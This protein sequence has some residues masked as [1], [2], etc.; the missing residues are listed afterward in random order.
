VQRLD[1]YDLLIRGDTSNDSR[2]L[3]GDVIFIP[4]VGPTASVTGE[5][6]RPAIYELRGETSIAD[7]VQIAGGLTPE[8]DANHGILTRIE[9]ASRRVVLDVNL[10]QP[11][12]RSRD[13]RNGDVLRV[14]RH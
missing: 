11:A 6:K 12:D 5:V 1:L 4:A 14:S 13:A 10:N 7:L 2:L 9:E 8:A 3:P